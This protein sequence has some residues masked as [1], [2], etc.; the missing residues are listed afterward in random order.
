LLCDT[1]QR[2]VRLNSC[3]LVKTR[4][5]SNIYKWVLLFVSSDEQGS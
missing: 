1:S 4:R 2:L 5:V 3:K